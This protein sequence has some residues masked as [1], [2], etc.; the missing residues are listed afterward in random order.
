MTYVPTHEQCNSNIKLLIFI[1]HLLYTK[2]YA[3]LFQAH[4]IELLRNSVSQSNF[5]LLSLSPFY[6]LKCIREVIY[7]LSFTQKVKDRAET[8]FSEFMTS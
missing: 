4:I 3:K 5:L 2:I 7:I 8:G 6:R 1:E